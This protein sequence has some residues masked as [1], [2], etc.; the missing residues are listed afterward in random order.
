MAGRAAAPVHRVALGKGVDGSEHLTG[1]A[2]TGQVQTTRGQAGEIR[3]QRPRGSQ[4][5]PSRRCRAWRRP[6]G[7]AGCPRAARRGSDRRTRRWAGCWGRRQLPLLLLLPVRG[8]PRARRRQPAARRRRRRPAAC[9][10]WAAPLRCIARCRGCGCLLVG[11]ASELRGWLRP[12]S[13]RL[14]PH[15]LHALRCKLLGWDLCRATNAMSHRAE[16]AREQ[17]VQG[18]GAAHRPS[19]ASGEGRGCVLPAAAQA[20]R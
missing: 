8:V 9:C 14:H 12:A 11:G 18:R 3:A 20:F 15:R 1:G 10:S 2:R 5:A 13:R 17:S 6:A 16:R 19:A 4:L 7:T